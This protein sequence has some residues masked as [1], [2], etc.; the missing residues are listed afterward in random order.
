MGTTYYM[1]VEGFMSLLMSMGA[2]YNYMSENHL[3]EGEGKLA[4]AWDFN[5]GGVEPA[6]S[7]LA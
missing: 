7:S 6:G 1:R 2:H 5:E 4:A 3:P